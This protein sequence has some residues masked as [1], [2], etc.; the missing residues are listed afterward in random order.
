M[1]FVSI[2]VDAIVKALSY[3]ASA[4]VYAGKPI[5][6]SLYNDFVS[7]YLLA[8]SFAFPNIVNGSIGEGVKSLYYFIMF[9][10]YDPILTVILVALGIL[11]LLNSSLQLGLDFRN[12]WIKVLLLL[13]LSNISFFLFQ[14]FLYMGSILYT[15]LWNFGVPAHN[16]SSGY[17]VLAGIEIGGSAGSI[18][19]LLILVIFVFLMLYMLLFLSMRAA[20]IYTLPILA[21]IFTLLL[22]IPR[23]KELGERIWFLFI[24]SL[25]API[26]MSIPLILATYVRKDSVLV[27]GF[28]AL[29][30]AV[31][32]MLAISQSSRSATG[33]L[34]KSVSRGVSASMNFPGKNM[35]GAQSIVSS[36]SSLSDSNGVKGTPET[37]SVRQ[38]SPLNSGGN[39]NSS[40]FFKVK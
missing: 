12:I 36:L 14:D 37:G 15:Q 16:F 38:F 39:S 10:I 21:P 25:V 7:K 27:L 32:T 6:V 28:L 40:L 22:I 8:P 3:I 31:P 24:D 30:D 29:A 33:Y 2:I 34:G 5:L 18:I 17:N 1:N 13:V 11:I 20:I 35:R 19:S 23:T 4:I 9:N 26:L